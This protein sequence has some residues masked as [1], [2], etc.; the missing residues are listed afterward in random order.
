MA[1]TSG[2]I[3]VSGRL[4]IVRDEMVQRSLPPECARDD[5]RRQGAVAVV[6]QGCAA[7]GER[8]RQVGAVGGNGDEGAKG[9]RSRRRVMWGHLG[10]DPGSDPNRVPIGV[11]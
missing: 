10:S 3:L 5:G 8:R 2:S 1:S 6:V 11:G 4:A 9:R 7:R